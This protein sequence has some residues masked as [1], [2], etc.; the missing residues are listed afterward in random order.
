[1][2]ISSSWTMWRWSISVL[3]D[4]TVCRLSTVPERKKVMSH[5][6]LQQFLVKLTGHFVWRALKRR[7]QYSLLQ[8]LP[9]SSCQR[10]CQVFM[11]PI[12]ILTIIQLKADTITSLTRR[13]GARCCHVHA[14]TVTVSRGCRQFLS[15]YYAEVVG[16]CTTCQQGRLCWPCDWQCQGCA[17]EIRTSTGKACCLKWSTAD[18]LQL[19]GFSCS[20]WFNQPPTGC[21]SCPLWRNIIL[22]LELSNVSVEQ[23]HRRRR[24]PHL[25]SARTFLRQNHDEWG[26]ASQQEES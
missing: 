10:F 21:L 26:V 7:Q 8:Q 3:N 5:I 13:S 4:E 23:T 12:S 6:Q 18:R 1:M 14:I 9:R 22:L 24:P 15:D 17:S 11:P 16:R 19:L 25:C 20:R 2:K